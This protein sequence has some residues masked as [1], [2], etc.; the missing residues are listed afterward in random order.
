MSYQTN[1][2]SAVKNNTNF[3]RVLYTGAK[4]QLVVMEISPGGDIGEEV[5]QHVEQILFFLSGSGQAVLES[6][7]SDVGA[8]DVVV[9]SPGVRHNFVNTGKEPLK[10]YT[11]YVPANHIDGRMHKTKKDADTDLED[12]AFGEAVELSI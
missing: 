4:S 5:H 7:I 1:I 9:V 2:V 6:K 3:R 8:G 11:I 12:E 10:L